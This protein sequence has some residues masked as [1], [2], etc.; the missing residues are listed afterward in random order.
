METME[1]VIK[2]APDKE[3]ITITDTAITTEW[4]GGI[5]YQLSKAD[6]SYLR[7]TYTE[8]GLKSAMQQAIALSSKPWQAERLLNDYFRVEGRIK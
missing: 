8:Y 1:E 7:Q 3:E 5:T 6:M 4:N 2:I